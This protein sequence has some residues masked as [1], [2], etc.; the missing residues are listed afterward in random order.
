MTLRSKQGALL[1][2]SLGNASPRELEIDH[3]MGGLRVD[4]SGAWARDADVRIS[5]RMGG[6]T[7][8]LPQDVEIVGLVGER[9]QAP[10]RDPELAQPKLNMTVSSWIGGISIVEQK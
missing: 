1:A 10:P 5:S 4:L 3:R 8:V 9:P 7:L 6:C 2:G